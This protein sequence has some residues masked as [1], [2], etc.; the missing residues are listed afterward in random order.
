MRVFNIAA[1]T[2]VALSGCSSDESQGSS[3]RIDPNVAC[4]DFDTPWSDYYAGMIEVGTQSRVQIALLDADP[5]PPD[6]HANSWTLQLLDMSERPMTEDVSFSRV[7]PWMPDHGHGTAIEPVVGALDA[8]G[9]TVVTGID[10]RMPGVWTV[11]YDIDTA[12]GPD[13]VVF[14]FCIDG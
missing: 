11:T 8:D 13:S 2:L 10:F 4:Q 12:N 5:A 1:I 6:L 7:K 3:S 9:K 14:S